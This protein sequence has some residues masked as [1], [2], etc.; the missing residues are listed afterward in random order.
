M[1]TSYM[2]IRFLL[3][4]ITCVLCTLLIG[5]GKLIGGAYRRVH[6][7]CATHKGGERS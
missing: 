3:V 6:L 4:L 1:I 2:G 5:I 7:L